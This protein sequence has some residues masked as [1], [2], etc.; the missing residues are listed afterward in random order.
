[1]QNKT[2]TLTKCFSEICEAYSSEQTANG[3][4]MKSTIK[5]YK[6]GIKYF[7]LYLEKC[8]HTAFK[9]VEKPCVAAFVP[10]ISE[11]LPGGLNT[12]LPGVRSFFRFL[13]EHD[14][15]QQDWDMSLRVV[16]ARKRKI[17]PGFTQEEVEG[18]LAASKHSMVCGKR[19]HAI[20]ILA[21]NTGLR[22]VDIIHLRLEDVDWRKNEIRISQ[23]KTG[24]ELTLPLLPD[25]GNAIAD[26]VLHERP[27]SE[28]RKIFL[29]VKKPYQELSNQ[30]MCNIVVRAA[31]A[32]NI[33]TEMKKQHGIRSFRRSVGL[34][35][36]EA[37][38]PLD[39]IREVLG[40]RSPNAIKP[41]LAI[42]NAHLRWCSLTLNGIETLRSELQ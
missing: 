1:M 37:E 22:S 35:M 3:V 18:I 39:L 16:L 20:L 17:Q 30:G 9:T 10:W 42:D 41:Y 27:V 14:I 33:D 25:V 32:S 21:A 40:H 15:F 12:V 7:L 24:N 4:L 6:A 31:K 8:G 19:D 29:S 23:H 38:I 2:K 28:C 5:S 11:R 34:R 13:N 36:L 26:Y